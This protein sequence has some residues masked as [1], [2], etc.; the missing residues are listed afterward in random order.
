MLF[1][2][3]PP[4]QIQPPAIVSPMETAE[5]RL[6]RIESTHF[7]K[8]LR[9]PAREVLQSRARIIAEGRVRAEED[10]SKAKS[11]LSNLNLFEYFSTL[12][13][14]LSKQVI[15]EERRMKHFSEQQERLAGLHVTLE[16]A[17][18]LLELGRFEE[19]LPLLRELRRE[20]FGRFPSEEFL[21]RLQQLSLQRE[22]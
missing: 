18:K 7:L 16:R 22:P 12:G 17:E 6:V 10:L 11:E 13:T 3:T 2:D 8:E 15:L 14:V 20:S 1:P 5:A 21:R 9:G 19:S 4:N